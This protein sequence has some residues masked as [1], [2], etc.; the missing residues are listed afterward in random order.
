MLTFY[1]DERRDN[2]IQGNVRVKAVGTLLLIFF[3]SSRAYFERL[4]QDKRLFYSECQNRSTRR[5]QKK[6]VLVLDLM[7]TSTN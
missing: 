2:A 4:P 5:R 6:H 7:G 1:R 3:L